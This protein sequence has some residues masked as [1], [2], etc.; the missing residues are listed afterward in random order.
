VSAVR[1]ARRLLRPFHGELV[2][3]LRALVRTDSVA[4]PPDGNETAAQRVLEAWLKRKRV[5]VE[6]YDTAFLERSKRSGLTAFLPGLAIAVVLHSAF[7]H[8]FLSPIVSAVGIVL[9]L[10]PLLYAVFEKSEQALGS[11]LG[12]GFDND[13]EMLALIN[14]G[15]LSDSPVGRYLHTLKDKF[16]GPVVADLLCY[17]RLTTELALRAKGVLMMRESGFEVAV[18]EA[19]KEKFAEL[20]YLESSI[21]KTGR[22]ALQPLLHLSHKDLWQLYMLKQ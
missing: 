20:R 17:L 7:N 9:I 18:D 16:K 8:F 15:Q 13:T 14:S 2:S 10:P 19:T 6:T 21:G 12:T 11:W 3:L 5:P 22:L 4:V 1:D